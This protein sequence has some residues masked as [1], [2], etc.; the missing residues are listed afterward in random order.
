MVDLK[1]AL[2]ILPSHG[3]KHQRTD[4]R[5]TELA[6]VG[7]AGEHEVD[8]GKTRVVLKDVDVVG[9]VDQKDDRR[10]GF[11]GDGQ[12]WVRGARAGVVRAGDVETLHVAFEGKVAV[13][14]HGRAVGFEL[15]DDQVGIDTDVMVAEH[16]DAL[17]AFEAGEDLGGAAGS[18]NGDAFWAGPTTDEVAGQQHHLRLKGVGAVDDLFEIARLCELFQVN[19][20]DLGEPHAH[21]RVREITDGEGAVGDF[22]LVTTVGAGIET[23]AQGGCAGTGEKGPTRQIGDGVCG[24]WRE[25]GDGHRPFY[26]GQPAGATPLAEKPTSPSRYDDEMLTKKRRSRAMRLAAEAGADSLLVTHGPD[27]RWL[28]GFTGSSGAMAI[29][30]GRAALFTDGR[31]T[32]QAK[33]EAPDMRVF[34][35]EKRSPMSLAMEWLAARGSAQCAF[36]ARTTTVSGLQAMRKALPKGLGRGFFVAT[37]DLVSGLREI[38]SAEE[39]KQMRKAAAL[40]CTLFEGVLP[41][42]VAGTTEI[43]VALELEYAA[44]QA[45]AE[46]MSFETIVASGKRSALPHGR[47]TGQ[48]LPRRGFVTLDFGV[49]WNGYCSDMTRTVHLGKASARARDVYDS[50]L[51]AQ[52][53]AVAAVGPGVACG[54]VDE[55][56]RT[57]LERARLGKWFSHSTGHGVG[58]EIHEGPRL[59][60]GVKQ[61]LK[62]GMVVTVEPGVYLPDELGVRIEDMVLVTETGSEVLTAASAKAWME[63]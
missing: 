9:F 29:R 13:N 37:E 19:V 3:G 23:N 20:G 22:D 25:F 5:K 24:R 7:V 57:V 56:A 14:Q 58:L 38:K 54:A 11:L 55:A 46:A 34:I 16:G 39:I 21:K 6:A 1:V 48:K 17:R 41:H 60:A 47:A 8:Q 12:V 53:A 42:M 27:V 30:G 28:S 35:K 52:E 36:D 18:A 50:V 32:A 63:L 33:T 40:G 15:M 59:A 61:V 2:D 4:E 43:G 26:R 31:Y 44:R 49:V 51:E 45:G 10:A 62:P